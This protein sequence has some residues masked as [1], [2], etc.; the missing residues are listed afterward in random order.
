MSVW[1]MASKRLPRRNRVAALAVA[2][3]MTM[4]VAGFAQD[5][6]GPLVVYNAG[7]LAVPFKMV[8]DAFALRYPEIRVQQEHSGSLAAVRKLTELDRIPDIVALADRTLFPALLE[9]EFT[10]WYAA[11]ARNA[12]VLAV[13]PMVEPG[14][15]GTA[16]NWPDVLLDRSV[17][18]GHADPAVD[19]A[20]Y[21][22]LMVFALAERHYG[23]QGL[24]LKL[25]SRSEPRYTR[26]KSAD[27]VALLQLG[28]LDYAWLYASV[29]RFHDLPFVTL[30]EA[31]NL[32]SPQ[33]ADEYRR[34]SVRVPGRTGAPEHSIEV[35]GRPIEL[36]VSV[37]LRA[38]H[39]EAAQAF[40]RFL[41]SE[42]GQS[43]MQRAGLLTVNPPEIYGSPPA[44]LLP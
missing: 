39:P 5:V 42:E 10:S 3:L 30:P 31:I 36:A 29:A 41:V 23:R 20:G 13:S 2:L 35:R 34:A 28:E 40:F 11:F 9:P 38:P 6:R 8:L 17:R 16:D 21:R 18:W 25:R 24:G 37:P 43:V 32:S 44:G 14:D 33:Y 22:T 26:P 19:P 27:L 1:V 12:M 15:R 7:S 4:P